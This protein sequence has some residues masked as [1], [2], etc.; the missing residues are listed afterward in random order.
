MADITMCLGDG[1][2]LK[3]SCYRHKATPSYYRQAYFLEPPYSE[4][5]GTCEFYWELGNTNG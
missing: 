1:C 5:N 2:N 4:E 3:N